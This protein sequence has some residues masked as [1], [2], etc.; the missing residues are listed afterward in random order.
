VT[1]ANNSVL[2][3]VTAYCLLLRL[4]A[5]NFNV[6]EVYT[7]AGSNALNVLDLNAACRTK[8]TKTYWYLRTFK[9]LL[10]KRSLPA[11]AVGI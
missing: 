9:C 4:K 11:H 10:K 5:I 1:K 3:W 2:D 7:F 8:R 6:E